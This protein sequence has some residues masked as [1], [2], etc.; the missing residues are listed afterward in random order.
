MAW[1]RGG[2]LAVE[3]SVLT[4]SPVTRFYHP[5]RR[6][7][8]DADW[9]CLRSEAFGILLT[10]IDR[11]VARAWVRSELERTALSASE[12]LPR[13]EQFGET[14]WAWLE[15]ARGEE[16]YDRLLVI[17]E[18]FR[19]C[20][21]ALG[22]RESLIRGVTNRVMVDLYSASDRERF[23]RSLGRV[24]KLGEELAGISQRVRSKPYL[25]RS[26]RDHLFLSGY[27]DIYRPVSDDVRA[28]GRQFSGEIG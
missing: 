22:S 18:Y 23:Q 2:E 21:A 10:Y 4:A 13:Y 14:L 7:P 3:G 8:N 19:R 20:M 9:A 17:G 5:D 24:Y 28:I 12:S 16:A 15:W 11:S 27:H 25:E 1:T 6:D 26:P